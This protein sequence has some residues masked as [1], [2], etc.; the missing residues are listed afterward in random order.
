MCFRVLFRAFCFGLPLVPEQDTKKQKEGN[1]LQKG[2]SIPC[3][4]LI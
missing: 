4:P 2:A 3:T 1:G